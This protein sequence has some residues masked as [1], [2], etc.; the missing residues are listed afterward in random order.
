[1]TSLGDYKRLVSYIYS[2]LGGM[3]DR[4]VGFAKAE[5]R[6]GMFKLN[7]SLKGVY[8]DVPEIFGIYLCVERNIYKSGS[9]KLL[10]MGNVIIKCGTAQYA[11]ILN[12]QNI[13][14]TGYSF[15]DVSGIAVVHQD[16]RFY[17]MFS[18]WDD[19]AF[20]PMA[21][22]ILPKDYKR[23]NK[24]FLQPSKSMCKECLQEK[25]QPEYEVYEV[26]KIQP[27]HEMYEMEKIQPE[28]EEEEVHLEH[29]VNGVEQMQQT[30]E[31]IGM[32]HQINEIKLPPVMQFELLFKE[33]DYVDAFSDDYCYDCIEITLE[34][35][36]KTPIGEEE[37]I[38]NSF[39]EHGYYNF[40]HL[41]FGRVQK[42]ER[43]TEYFIGV[44]GMYCN[45]ERF[46]ASMF[47][48]NNFKK[49]HRSD[50]SN[51]YFGYWY[52]EI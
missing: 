27:E 50:Y 42:N 7:V 25:V 43:H 34:E 21:L 35:L 33:C 12:A 29:K 13:N 9:C 10:H 3:R 39:L 14:N 36:K 23:E 15:Q 49:S 26:E 5:V 11:D 22:E 24:V 48:F 41:L 20:D 17:M 51:P 40:R 37:I 38:N 16:N 1:M 6:G 4:N 8:T 19:E 47:G 2:Y 44:P 52:Q 45:R 30:S 31:D 46:M 18:L 32:V 28:H